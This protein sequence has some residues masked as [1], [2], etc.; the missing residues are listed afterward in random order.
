MSRLPPSSTLFPSTTLFRSC[1]DQLVQPSG[2]QDQAG[3]GRA[4]ALAAAGGGPAAAVMGEP[5]GVSRRVVACHPA[6]PAPRLQSGEHTSGLQA[7]TK[8]PSR[9]SLYRK[10]L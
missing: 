6:A 7:H 2:G 5:S 9:L 3:R 10:T 4:E 8:S 1:V